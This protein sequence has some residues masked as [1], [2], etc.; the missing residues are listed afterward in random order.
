M[1]NVIWRAVLSGWFFLLSFGLFANNDADRSSMQTDAETP[2]LWRLI[3]KLSSKVDFILD[4]TSSVPS[5]Y[6]MDEICLSSP[7]PR[8]D[9]LA[10]RDEARQRIRDKGVRFNGHYATRPSDVEEKDEAGGYLELSWD[11]LDQGWKGREREASYLNA[12]AELRNL[13]ADKQRRQQLRR[14]YRNN[15]HRHFSVARATLLSSR[16]ELLET[17]YEVEERAYFK[18]WS[19]IDD[20]WI[21]ERDLV[22]TRQE[23]AYLNNGGLSSDTPAFPA[24]IPPVLDLRMD[25][26]IDA[27]RRDPYSEQYEKAQQRLWQT[28]YTQR[29]DDRLRLYLRQEVDEVGVPEDIVAGLRFSIPLHEGVDRPSTYWLEHDR[30]ERVL[31]TWERIALVQGSYIEV[32]EQ[33]ERVIKQYYA[34]QRNR[35]RVRRSLAEYRHD[36]QSDLTVALTR[37]LGYLTAAEEM[38]ATTEVLYR[39]IYDLLLKAELNPEPR[40]I[41]KISLAADNRQRPGERTIYV[42]SDTFN[43][44]DNELLLNVA[45]AKGIEKLTLS[46][47]RKTDREKLL[48][49]LRHDSGVSVELTIGADEW[50]RPE[51]HSRAI[52]SVQRVAEQNLAVHL[53]LEPHRLPEYADQQEFLQEAYVALISKIK[54]ALPPTSRLTLSVPIHWPA[55]LYTRLAE[56]ADELYLMAYDP[57]FENLIRRLS[58]IMA[59]VPNPEQQ[60]RIIQR[61]SD[62]ADEWALEK[63]IRRLAA[64]LP[65]TRFGL[66]DLGELITL[67][68]QT[69]E[70]KNP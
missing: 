33:L 9:V 47:G 67:T 69:I 29:T 21:S 26:V 25:A 39:R 42:W 23:L 48:A 66:H 10:L 60:L 63:Q 43:Q 16:L 6:G 57:R 41:K 1:S 3:D 15:L 52:S 55:P 31:D 64:A 59:S 56:L 61:P 68:S 70:I 38:A 62:F 45:K 7:Q 50:I 49:L 17:I 58:P 5:H 11:L 34:L 13:E 18:G 44:L 2:E 14:C 40:F 27:I 46:A 30:N 36:A 28:R 35:E 24:I 8:A 54:K 19:F 65:I 51:N 53:D 4:Q 37:T 22:L 12:Q 32:Q 20:L